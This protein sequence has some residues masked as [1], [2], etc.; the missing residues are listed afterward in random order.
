MTGKNTS[1]EDPEAREDIVLAC[2]IDDKGTRSCP[3]YEGVD[4][5]LDPYGRGIQYVAIC[6]IAHMIRQEN[7]RS[8]KQSAKMKSIHYRKHAH[9]IGGLSLAYFA[10]KFPFFTSFF[11]SGS[12][13]LLVC[14]ILRD[15]VCHTVGWLLFDGRGGLN[16]LRPAKKVK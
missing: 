16:G 6:H 11:V 9:R 2:D 14:T 12:A 8:F 5:Q 4:Q 3:S 15:R 1:S 10:G 13:P 7:R